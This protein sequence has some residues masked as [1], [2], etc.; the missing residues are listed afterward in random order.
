MAMQSLQF[1]PG[2]PAVALSYPP[3]PAIVLNAQP[4]KQNQRNGSETP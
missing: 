2:M 3:F 4:K 1:K